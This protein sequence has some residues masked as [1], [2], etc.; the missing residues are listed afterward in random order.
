MSL[1]LLSVSALTVP[2]QSHGA[3]AEAAAGL[4]Q[5][6]LEQPEAM[7]LQSRRDEAH[8]VALSHGIGGPRSS[9]GQEEG[10]R[11]REAGEGARGQAEG[12][13]IVVGSGS[14]GASRRRQRLL[15][16]A[17]GTAGGECGIEQPWTGRRADR[18]HGRRRQGR[19][20][21]E[22]AQDAHQSHPIASRHHLRRRHRPVPRP[23]PGPE[24]RQAPL[25]VRSAHE[26]VPP[27]AGRH[28]FH[29]G[30]PDLHSRAVR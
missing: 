3:R 30:L 27:E 9:Q 15:E 16:E 10:R 23:P 13:V 26:E 7:V 28:G 5:R 14:G 21:Q 6:L 1:I 12:G 29:D 4:V 8:P 19:A 11:E 24:P 22:A 25:P 2:D 17:T 20:V 18:R